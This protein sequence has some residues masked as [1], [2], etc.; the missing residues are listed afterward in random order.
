MAEYEIYYSEL[1]EM[2]QRVECD[3]DQLNEIKDQ[4][5]DNTFDSEI[6]ASVATRSATITKIQIVVKTDI[7]I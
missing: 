5:A 3:E 2:M 1:R 6:D 4:I 7:P